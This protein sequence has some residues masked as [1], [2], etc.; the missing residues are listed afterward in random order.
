[1]ELLE[2]IQAIVK[3]AAEALAA[4]KDAAAVEAVRAKTI[5]RNGSFTALGPLMGKVPPEDKP[6]MGRAFNEAKQELAKLLEEAK[7]QNTDIL[8]TTEKD[9]VK[10]K[11]LTQKTI[12]ALKLG[13]DWDA[14][15]IL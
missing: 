10:I 9:A 14:E 7:T 1:M 3:D 11:T 4:A 5:G 13:I 6:K 8:I 2:Q 12:Y 15:T